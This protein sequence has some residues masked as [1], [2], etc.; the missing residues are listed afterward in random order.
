MAHAHVTFD[1]K[2]WGAGK[3]EGLHVGEDLGLEQAA[4]RPGS[5]KP[6]YQFVVHWT[7]VLVDQLDTLVAAVVRVTVVY[8]D[9]EAVC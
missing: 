9:V 4:L 3:P 1:V 2:G 6:A 5:S 7:A 8:Y